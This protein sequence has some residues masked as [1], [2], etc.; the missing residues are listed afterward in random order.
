MDN[1][2]KTSTRIDPIRLNHFKPLEQ[3]EAAASFIFYLAGAISFAP[4][5]LDSKV[6]PRIFATLLTVFVILVI[7]NFLIGMVNRLYFM[8]RAEDARRKEFL[9]N[10]YQF[11]LIHERTSGYYNNSETDPIRRIGLSTL[12]NL[13]FSKNIL[14]LMAPAARAKALIY[15]LAWLSLAIW[16]ET[17]LGWLP[18]AAQVIFSEEL[19]SRWLRLEWARSRAEILY[20]SMHRLFQINPD[21]DKLAAYSIA[22]FVDYEAGKSLGGILL[23]KKIFDKTNKHLTSEW[24]QIKTGLP[25]STQ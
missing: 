25:L 22:T 18:V 19:I 13:F 24:E 17:P 7:S 11:D 1:P 20:E 15:M 21:K 3:S 5:L 2:A 14:R 6:H 16:R 10:A 4:L 9:S 8:P 23:S 12:E